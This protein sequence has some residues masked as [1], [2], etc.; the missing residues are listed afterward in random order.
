M[1][2]IT[3]FTLVNFLT[4]I[5]ILSTLSGIIIVPMVY[6]LL[7]DRS[8]SKYDMAHNQAILS[9]MR[10]SFEQRFAKLNHEL[11]AT[12]A[13]WRDVNHLLLSAQRAQRDQLLERKVVITNFFRD[14]GLSDNDTEVD[15]K[16]VF[17]LT[18]LNDEEQETYTIIKDVCARN[19]LTCL[20]GDEEFIK[21]DILPHVVKLMVKARIVIANIGSRNPNVYY[22]L[23]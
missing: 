9:E 11:M 12:E 10:A 5:T 7:R 16:L 20:R 22:E 14:L 3:R 18:P 23:G 4:F 13:R 15:S 17:V 1:Q 21:G 6:I 2:D 8:K 19:G